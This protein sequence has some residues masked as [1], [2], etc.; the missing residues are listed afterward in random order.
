MRHVKIVVPY[1]PIP[2]FGHKGFV[3]WAAAIALGPIV[4]VRRKFA[5][6]RCLMA[7]ELTHVR[8][9]WREPLTMPFKYL[10]YWLRY[11]YFENPYEVE[12]F[13]VERRCR[14]GG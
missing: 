10:Y 5:G 6:D 1:L 2:I 7:H 8:Q 3:G 14:R 11:G 4:I 13:A 9:W 12:A